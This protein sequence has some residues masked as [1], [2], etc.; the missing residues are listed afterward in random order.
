MTKKEMMIKAHELTREIKEEFPEVDY[1]FQLSICMKFIREGEDMEREDEKENEEVTWEMIQE[2]ADKYCEGY[3][4][5][6]YAN[7]YCKNWVKGEHDRT[8]I[9]IREYRK[10]NLR[11]LK[12]CG[13]WDNIKKEY[14]SYDRR[15]R[16][17]DLIE[18]LK[19]KKFGGIKNG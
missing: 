19:K 2:A 16:T 4:N 1:K 15:H 10:G 13:Y 12:S 6:W 17:I 9:E 7:W 11:H 5:G 3:I 18:Y 14:V 8:Y